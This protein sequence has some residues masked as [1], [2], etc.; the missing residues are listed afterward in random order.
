VVTEAIVREVAAMTARGVPLRYALLQMT[1][2]VSLDTWHSALRRN[3]SFHTLYERARGE[4]LVKACNRLV[5]ERDPANLRW[6]LERRHPE[7]FG[8]GPDASV[9]VN[10]QTVVGLPEDVLDRARALAAK[11]PGGH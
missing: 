10:H 6:I 5:S 3:A 9:T 4:F 8:K 7:H 11:L 2:P 1:P